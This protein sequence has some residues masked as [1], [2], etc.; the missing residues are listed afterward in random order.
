MLPSPSSLPVAHKFHD[1]GSE[2]IG[3]NNET[4]VSGSENAGYTPLAYG[5]WNVECGLSENSSTLLGR[6]M[7]KSFLCVHIPHSTPLSPEMWKSFHRVHVPHS[8]SQGHGIWTVGLLDK[9]GS[10]DTHKGK[11]AHDYV[12]QMLLHGLLGAACFLAG[13]F[14]SI[15]CSM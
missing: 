11:S 15:L 9:V 13:L 5:M 7:W 6:G 10:I 1:S 12:T 8:T 3:R 4:H 14:H 2:H